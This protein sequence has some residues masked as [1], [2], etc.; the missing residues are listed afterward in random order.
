MLS[1]NIGLTTQTTIAMTN[2]SGT[3]HIYLDDME[4]TIQVDDPGKAAEL[5]L[6]LTKAVAQRITKLSDQGKLSENAITEG[7]F[8]A[9]G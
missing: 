7:K 4:V 2:Y 3:P 9:E 1:V 8:S 5:A 6:V